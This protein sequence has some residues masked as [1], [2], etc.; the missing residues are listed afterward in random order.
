MD[1]DVAPD[2]AGT[3]TLPPLHGTEFEMSEGIGPVVVG[4]DSSAN[5]RRAMLAAG[6][7]AVA[8]GAGLIV[9]HA[10]G[11]TEEIDGEH[12]PTHTHHDEIVAAVDRCCDA[13]RDEGHDDFDVRLI[14]GAPV[15][16]VLRTAEAENASTIVVGRRGVGGR[17]ELR[18]GSTAHQ[19]IEHAHCPVLIIP[20]LNQAAAGADPA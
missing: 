10:V 9:V 8:T 13:L 11:L 12:V 17:P 14:D 1:H 19:I 2:V 5:A 20:P 4:I 18:L 16:A 6:R 3:T 7:H 15:D